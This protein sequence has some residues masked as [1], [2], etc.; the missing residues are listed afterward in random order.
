MFYCYYY[1]GKL[2]LEYK[3][4]EHNN[5][6]DWFSYFS[7]DYLIENNV[8]N[9]KENN[10]YSNCL[11]RMY[12]YSLSLYDVFHTANIVT[13]QFHIIYHLTNHYPPISNGINAFLIEIV[14]NSTNLTI[15]PARLTLYLDWLVHV[16]NN[17]FLVWKSEN[18][19][20]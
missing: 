16:Y 9:I 14:I 1:G 17:T 13:F 4:P 2:F 3:W 5:L 20:S 19:K 8:K 7:V 12:F 6:V 18:S 15:S 10:G 11:L